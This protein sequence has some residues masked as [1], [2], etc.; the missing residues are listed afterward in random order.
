M[1]NYSKEEV[2]HKKV[3]ADKITR[4]SVA[5][6]HTHMLHNVLLFVRVMFEEEQRLRRGMDLSELKNLDSILNVKNLRPNSAYASMQ[7]TSKDVMKRKH[8]LQCPEKTQSEDTVSCSDDNKPV[9]R[10]ERTF[11][12]EH[13][14]I[15]SKELRLMKQQNRKSMPIIDSQKEEAIAN[16]SGVKNGWMIED[17]EKSSKEESKDTW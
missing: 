16:M 2:R 11:D 14:S 17:A 5:I 10:R 1:P 12:L 8:K 15:L 13:G 6:L 4:Y 7:N 9:L 3:L